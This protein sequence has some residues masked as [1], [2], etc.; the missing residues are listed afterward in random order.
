MLSPKN[1]ALA[2]CVRKEEVWQQ[3]KNGE[4]SRWPGLRQID[5]SI[6]FP[7]TVAVHPSLL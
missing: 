6:D 1:V 2:N 3:R 4:K 7:F 5:S